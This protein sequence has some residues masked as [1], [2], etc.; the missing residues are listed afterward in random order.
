MQG[1][2]EERN[3]QPDQTSAIMKEAANRFDWLPCRLSLEIP[4]SGFTLG[5]LLRLEKDSVVT[6]GLR[7]TE[8]IPLRVNRRLIAWIQFEVIGDRLAA[9]ITELA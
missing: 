9:R 2:Q 6:T 1:Q 4:V 8:D 5:D 3:D 7:T